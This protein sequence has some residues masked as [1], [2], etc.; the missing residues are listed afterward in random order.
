MFRVGAFVGWS[1]E[2]EGVVCKTLQIRGL[3]GC[4]VALIGFVVGSD[5]VL[6]QQV[7]TQTPL[8]NN[9]TRFFE[10]SNISWGVRNPHYFFS[11]NGGGA[12]P[13]FGGFQP[14]AG[15]NGGFTI[16]NAQF[17]FGF[18]QGA[19]STSSTFAP[20]LT[21]TS[22]YPGSLFIGTVRP[23]VV[24]AAPVVGAGGF[25]NVAPAGP[26]AERIATG[27]LRVEEGRVVPTATTV[28]RTTTASQPVDLEKQLAERRTGVTQPAAVVMASGP[29]PVAA[30]KTVPLDES[31][32][33]YLDRGAAAEKEGKH[34]LAKVFYQLAA[35][36]G[37]GLVR[38][39]AEAKL[40]AMKTSSR[41]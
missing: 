15:L 1:W 8:Q 28:A 37:D 11:F 36:K 25:G 38:L 4:A 41:K 29:E 3:V 12:A 39:E 14:N 20:M 21:T 30:K 35:T 19:S 40:A 24:G 5:C 10:Q 27:Q 9:G 2:T 18:A 6:A 34:G 7:T 22:G 23:F 13:P 26:L 32:A 16:G 33:Q 31:A 17:N